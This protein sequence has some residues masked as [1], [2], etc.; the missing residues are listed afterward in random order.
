[1]WAGRLIAYS[2]GGGI[3]FKANDSAFVGRK[4]PLFLKTVAMLLPSNLNNTFI[5]G[6]YN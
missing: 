4:A 6:F 3:L 2:S 5:F 1:M